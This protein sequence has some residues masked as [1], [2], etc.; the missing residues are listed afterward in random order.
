MR[1][2]G[3]SGGVLMALTLSLVVFAVHVPGLIA[4]TVA[5]YA[6]PTGTR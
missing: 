6:E 3:V 4:F 1:G 2:Y 5:R